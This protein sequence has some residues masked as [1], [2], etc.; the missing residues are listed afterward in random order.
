LRE[1]E[2]EEVILEEDLIL[3]GRRSNVGRKKK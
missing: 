2:E 3:R 1:E